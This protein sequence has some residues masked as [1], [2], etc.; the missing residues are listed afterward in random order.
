[1]LCNVQILLLNGILR[2]GE[3]AD[4]PEESFTPESVFAHH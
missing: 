2:A 3:R 4:D 1:M